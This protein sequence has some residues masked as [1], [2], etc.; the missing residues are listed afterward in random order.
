MANLRKILMFDYVYTLS[1]VLVSLAVYNL[2]VASG[3]DFGIDVSFTWQDL[4]DIGLASGGT[5][6]CI[7][8]VIAALLAEV[9][10]TFKLNV[11]AKILRILFVFLAVLFMLYT[12][13]AV[14][15][16][17]NSIFGLPLYVILYGGAF[18]LKKTLSAVL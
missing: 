8:I 15:E 6:Y 9:T 5:E 10:G 1:A 17:A 13:G 7:W 12:L 4:E 3:G 14:G 16:N 11:L 2:P 18:W